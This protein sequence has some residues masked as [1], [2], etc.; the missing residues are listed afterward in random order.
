MKRTRLGDTIVRVDCRTSAAITRLAREMGVVRKDVI[1][2]AV[3]RLRRQRI[4]ESAN[5]GFAA[6]KRERAAWREEVDERKSW[7]VTLSDGLADH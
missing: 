1:T 3:E 6:I 2:H 7:E 4:M 5:E